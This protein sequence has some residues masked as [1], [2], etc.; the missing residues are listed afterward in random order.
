MQARHVILRLLLESGRGLV[1]VERVTGADGRPDI[2]VCLDRSLIETQG[3][4]VIQD[5][6][7]KLQVKSYERTTPLAVPLPSPLSLFQPLIRTCS[8]SGQTTNQDTSLN[9]PPH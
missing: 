6:L 5:F 4:P 9:R 3:K 1:R 2:L 8:Y 7:M